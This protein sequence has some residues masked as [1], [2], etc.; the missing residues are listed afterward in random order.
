MEHFTT[1]SP[2]WANSHCTKRTCNGGLWYM[3]AGCLSC[4]G[5]GAEFLITLLDAAKT[6]CSALFLFVFLILIKSRANLD[7][8][9]LFGKSVRQISW[10]LDAVKLHLLNRCW[11]HSL[12]R[13]S[14]THFLTVWGRKSRRTEILSAKEPRNWEVNCSSNSEL[15]TMNSTSSSS[16]PLFVTLTV[17]HS[18]HRNNPPALC[19]WEQNRIFVGAL[20]GSTLDEAMF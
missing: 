6:G 8:S 10:K 11:L 12:E 13:P 1:G 5:L 15:T 20:W 7:L 3:M 2:F 9:L 18:W 17:S 4:A 14:W 19:W 16:G